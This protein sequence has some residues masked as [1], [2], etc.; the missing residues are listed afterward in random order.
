MQHVKSLFFG[1]VICGVVALFTIGFID[2]EAIRRE[3]CNGI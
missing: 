1:D 3:R 2:E